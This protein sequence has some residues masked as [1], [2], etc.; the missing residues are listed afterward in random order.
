[1]KAILLGAVLAV[2]AVLTFGVGAASAA[3]YFCTIDV[4]GTLWCFR[5]HD[6]QPCLVV[7]TPTSVDVDCRKKT[8]G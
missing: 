7:Q 3:P 1:M 2:S 4:A 8:I 5:K 6:A